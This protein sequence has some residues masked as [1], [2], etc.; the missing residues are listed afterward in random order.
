MKDCIANPCRYFNMKLQ[1][2]AHGNCGHPDLN[3][4]LQHTF[5]MGHPRL[6][7]GLYEVASRLNRPEPF[8]RVMMSSVHS[9]FWSFMFDFWLAGKFRQYGQQKRPVLASDGLGSTFFNF[10]LVFVSR[11]ESLCVPQDY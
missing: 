8:S 2:E 7:H 4:S 11:A 3:G 10:T 1:R 9:N 5:P 6:P